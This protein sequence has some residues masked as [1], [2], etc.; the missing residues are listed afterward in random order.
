MVTSRPTPV[1]TARR[2]AVGLILRGRTAHV[3]GPIAGTVGTILSLVNQGEV[4]L[5]GQA[6]W[7]TWVRIV[8][9]Y[10]VPYTVGSLVYLSACRSRS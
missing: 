4:I 7:L 5:S 10:L 3:A 8:I 1:W 9:N 2:E 6:T